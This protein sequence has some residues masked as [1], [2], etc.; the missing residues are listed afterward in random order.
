M[1]TTS[2][3]SS[4]WFFFILFSINFSCLYNN[5][6]INKHEVFRSR[7]LLSI[8]SSSILEVLDQR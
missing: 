1:S 7:F 3:S 2:S 8:T 6:I 4:F 5:H